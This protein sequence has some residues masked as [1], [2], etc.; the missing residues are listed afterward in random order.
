MENEESLSLLFWIST[1][2]ML[3][4]AIG[5]LIITLIYHKKTSS[6]KQKESENLLKATLATEKKERKRIASDIHDSISNDLSAIRNYMSLLHQ[7]EEN[8][9]RKQIFNEISTTLDTMQNNVRHINYSLMPPTL[10]SIGLIPTLNEYIERQSLLNDTNI[11]TDFKIDNPKFD[12]YVSYEIY[13]TLQEI[14]SNILKHNK[15]QHIKISMFKNKG[16]ITVHIKDDGF[17]FNFFESLKTSKGLGLKNIISRLHYI[18]AVLEQPKTKKGNEL[19][20]KL[21]D[22]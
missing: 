12:S 2:V 15:V 6:I 8:T 4:L 14:I 17:Y 13:R 11:S 18:D 21:K 16:K 5:F 20:I 9:S 22:G 1:A 7:K 19:L 3:L 10:E